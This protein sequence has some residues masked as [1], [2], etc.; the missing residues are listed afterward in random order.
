MLRW[1][2]PITKAAR[3]YKVNPALIAAIISKESAGNARAW[4][5]R[6]DARG[7]MQVRHGPW[8]PRANVNRGTALFAAYY[9]RFHSLSLALAAYNAGPSNVVRYGGIPPFRETQRYVPAVTTLYL[10]YRCAGLR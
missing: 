3:R 9:Q 5:R 2:G 6:T 8:S 4:N 10:R 7:L 1:Q